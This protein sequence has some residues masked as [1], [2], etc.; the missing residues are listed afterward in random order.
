MKP[1]ILTTAVFTALLLTACSKNKTISSKGQVIEIANWRYNKTAVPLVGINVCF[2]QGETSDNLF[3]SGFK[4]TGYFKC[5]LTDA[6]G[7]FDIALEVPRK[8]N[9]SKQYRTFLPDQPGYLFDMSWRMPSETSPA[10][11]ERKIFTLGAYKEIPVVLTLNNVNYLNDLD[12]LIIGSYLHFT[13]KQNNIV[14]RGVFTGYKSSDNPA[15]VGGGFGY[16][17]FRNNIEIGYVN[18]NNK[19]IL[20]GDTGYYTIN[21]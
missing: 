17:V 14:I 8:G 9:L 4:P 19:I 11:E 3:G 5:M 6:E 16:Q 1:L 13:G 10:S 15:T 20:Q 12:S 7:K 21:Y 2:T 18:F